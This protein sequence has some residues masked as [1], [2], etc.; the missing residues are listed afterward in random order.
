L[1]ER[2]LEWQEKVILCVESGVP[3]LK[4]LFFCWASF[5]DADASGFKTGAAFGLGVS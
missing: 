3:P 1:F 5:P 2:K 4:G